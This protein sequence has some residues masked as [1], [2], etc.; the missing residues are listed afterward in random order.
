MDSICSH[1]RG[2]WP[3]F[4]LF[5]TRIGEEPPT[6]VQIYRKGDSMKGQVQSVFLAVVVAVLL[7]VSAPAAQVRDCSAAVP[8]NQQGHWSWR[9]IDGR[10]CWYAGKTMISKSLLKWPA[11][12]PAQMSDAAP[13]AVAA[14]KR[15]EP[16]DAQARMLDD[17]DSF[18]SRWRAR[19][20][21]E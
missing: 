21:P 18:E 16:M 3:N 11:T 5:V 13:I 8:S 6:R 17:D 15:S 1:L 10:K 4:R 12:A 2:K 19:A 14:E 9:L 20:I 7:P